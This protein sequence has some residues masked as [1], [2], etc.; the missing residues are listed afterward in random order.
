MK[1]LMIGVI[2]AGLFWGGWW[3]WAAHN[4]RATTQAWFDALARD[5][6]QASYDDLS[7]RGFPNRLDTTMT[8]LTLGDP[9]GALVWQAPFFQVF[10]LVYNANH[11]IAAWPDDQSLTV[12]GTR[13]DIRDTGLRASL[14]QDGDGRLLRMNIE[15][16]TLSIR[17]DAKALAL[18]GFGAALHAIDGQPE[19]YQLTLGLHGLDR[20]DTTPA[21]L[22]DSSLDGLRVEARVTFD[23]PWTT[24]AVTGPRPQPIR[25]D[26]TQANFR[27]GDLSVTMTGTVNLDDSGA[28]T[29]T[30]TATAVNWR[31]LL[32]LARDTGAI[33]D[34]IAA[35][36]EQRLTL[37]ARRGGNGQ[38][39]DLPLT[40][41][42]GQMSLGPVPIGPAPRLR[43]P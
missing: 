12:N 8:G 41:S 27:L 23:A 13:Y 10:Q 40:L 34:R 26:L 39:L 11:L 24:N 22:N 18:A 29:G 21:S 37:F 19:D 33:S 32:A 38:T 28:M 20:A 4:Q 7:V 31:D 17:S 43:L 2:L 1:R 5:G 3:F 30:L 15:A 9:D 35:Q 25:I 6:W 42:A 16:Q 36:L 14:V